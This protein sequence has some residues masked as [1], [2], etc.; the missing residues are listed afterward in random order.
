[1]KHRNYV[2]MATLT[3]E[4]CEKSRDLARGFIRYE[5][6]RTLNPIQFTE[7]WHKSMSGFV[8]FDDLVDELIQDSE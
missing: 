3:A 1:M 6:V 7:L 5:K 2:E 8:K 4:V